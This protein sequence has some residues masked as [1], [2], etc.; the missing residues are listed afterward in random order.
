MKVFSTCPLCFC[1]T[2]TKLWEAS[3]S[4]QASHF[5]SPLVNKKKYEN[6]K[7]HI[8]YLQQT[9][10]I[11]VNKCKNCNFIYS[12][13]NFA[14]DKK[15]YDLIFS[16]TNKYPQNR[17]EFMKSIDIIKN[18]NFKNPKILEIG[19]GDGAFI[20]KLVKKRIT[21]KNAITAIE[22]SL[23]GKSKIK[24]FGVNCLSIDVKDNDNKLPHKEYDWDPRKYLGKSKVYCQ[25]TQS[26]IGSQHY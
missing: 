14:G 11:S 20:R 6:L 1:Y 12:F 2:A 24:N 25:Q 26:L 7:A 21:T 13:P 16:D 4:Q 8:E 23:Y 10:H 18:S 5:L 3:S 9:S 17:W 22:Y 19:S 15:F